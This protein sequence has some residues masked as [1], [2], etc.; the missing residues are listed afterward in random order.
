MCWP[1]RSVYEVQG[2]CLSFRCGG[3]S[4]VVDGR[5]LIVRA[6]RG[7]AEGIPCVSG[8]LLES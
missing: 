4:W 8:L 2:L 1:S 3:D 6:D 5:G 7:V